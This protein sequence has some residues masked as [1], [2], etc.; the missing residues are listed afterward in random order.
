[1]RSSPDW[2]VSARA[3]GQDLVGDRAG[4]VGGFG[5]AADIGRDFLRALGGFFDIAG[6]FLGRGALLFHRGGD[7]GGDLVDLADRLADRGDGLAPHS[8]SRPAR[9]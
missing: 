6:D 1:M 7:G 5:D 9:W 4:A 8:G 3:D 2:P